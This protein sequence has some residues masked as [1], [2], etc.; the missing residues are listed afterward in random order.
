MNREVNHKASSF[1]SEPK[2]GSR[3]KQAEHLIVKQPPPPPCSAARCSRCHAAGTSP[4]E[5]RAIRRIQGIRDHPLTARN[6]GNGFSGREAAHRAT[7]RRNPR[8]T[9]C[10]RLHSGTTQPPIATA[11][12]QT[13]RPGAHN[14]CFGDPA[15]EKKQPRNSS[16]SDRSRENSPR[17]QGI[18]RKLPVG[19]QVRRARATQTRRRAAAAP[20]LTPS[21][22]LPSKRSGSGSSGSS[23]LALLSLLSLAPS[24]SLAWQVRSPRK[25]RPPACNKPAAAPP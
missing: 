1:T 18:R 23:P 11:K 15:K 12:G 24:S 14:W 21:Q 19:K 2:S 22:D 16:L 20:L 6:H 3:P 9:A 10:A 4:G 7:T 17:P 5:S 13:R 25:K 8:I